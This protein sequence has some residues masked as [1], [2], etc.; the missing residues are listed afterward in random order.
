MFLFN[1]V[2]EK[3]MTVIGLSHIERVPG[4]PGKDSSAIK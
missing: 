4:F 1:S 3:K 2:K